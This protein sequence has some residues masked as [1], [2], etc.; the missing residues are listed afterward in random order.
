MK[1]GKV[2]AAAV[3]PSPGEVFAYIELA[4]ITPSPVNPRKFFDAGKLAELA[5]S[6]KAKGVIS[7][8]LIRP[9]NGNGAYEL[10]AGER[11]YR[12]SL[13][14]GLAAIPAIVRELSDDD[15]LEIMTIENLQR[16]DLTEL[17]EAENFKTYLGAKGGD[18]LIHLAERIGI[19][20][21]YIRRRVK[22]LE[23]LDAWGKGKLLYGHLEQFLRLGSAER[24]LKHYKGLTRWANSVQ[25]VA[26]LREQI[27]NE[28]PNLHGAPFAKDE[29][30]K[31][32][33]NSSVQKSLF[34]ELD[35][36][37]KVRCHDPKCFEGKLVAHLTE[38]WAESEGAKKY[39]T[40]GFRLSGAVDY[41]HYEHVYA[42][43]KDKECTTCAD[44]VSIIDRRGGIYQQ[45]VCLK[46]Q[47]WR[48]KRGRGR[49]AAGS[50]QK[51]ETIARDSRERFYQARI[52][53]AV[54]A[55]P[56]DYA[57]QSDG[58]ESAILLRLTLATILYG[59]YGSD[60]AQEICKRAGLDS[61]NFYN[62]G[63]KAYST[64]MALPVDQVKDLFKWVAVNFA[65]SAT[66]GHLQHHQLAPLLGIDL[67]A[68]WKITEG[69]LKPKTIAQIL[70][71]GKEVGILEE[72][73]A[74]EYLKEKLHAKKFEALKKDQLMEL[75]LK[76]GV[77][78]VGRVPK[79]VL[80][81]KKT[82]RG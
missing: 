42:G 82:E 13:D 20:S 76:C 6:I 27:N 17:E 71:V 75:V 33:H 53:K 63:E 23:L 48:Q 51:S 72:P 47:C 24:A 67:K 61:P 35:N 80:E 77:P 18:A 79:E 41:N 39:G 45:A 70:A 21:Q 56:A 81:I 14:A 43:G 62:W 15:A 8:V 9:L 26:Q 36:E 57:F 54:A 7:P 73:K 37:K 50:E 58:P 3:E 66:F 68:E 74:V 30:E 32:L 52:R 46:P 1:K 28:A 16:E 59:R 60:M 55:L 4:K 69:Y 25:T 19:T 49:A 44:L 65:S 38:H 34:G 40:N 12:A 31:C 78:L 29:C 11:R 64:L 5:E 10:V 2:Q 22:V